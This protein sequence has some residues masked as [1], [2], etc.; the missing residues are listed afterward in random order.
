VQADPT[1]ANAWF[2]LGSSLFADA[3]IDSN[4]KVMMT[5][6]NRQA[7]QKYLELSP[8]GPH[9]ADVKAMLDMSAK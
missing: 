6:E 4:G 7:L 5:A 1:L 3:K 9:A 2:V 8:D